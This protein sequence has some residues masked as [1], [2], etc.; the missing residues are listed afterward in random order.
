MPVPALL[1]IDVGTS[2]CRAALYSHT[3]HSLAS[4]SIPYPLS[5]P[6]ARWVEQDAESYWEAAGEG[7]RRMLAEV[8][9]GGRN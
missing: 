4:R 2:G 1:G 6:H 9:I 5:R 8:G 3:G 7:V